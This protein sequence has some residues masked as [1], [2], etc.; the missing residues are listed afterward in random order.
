MFLRLVSKGR[1]V[2]SERDPNDVIRLA[3]APNPGTAHIWEQALSDEGI[4]AKVVGDYLDAGF[5]DMAGAQPE[6]WI[7]RLDEKKAKMVLDRH[8]K[9][10]GPPPQTHR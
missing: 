10:G 4:E 7:H 5:G 3:I 9:H 8:T 6:V 2:M 1:A